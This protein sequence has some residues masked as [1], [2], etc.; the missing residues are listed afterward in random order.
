VGKRDADETY[1]RYVRRQPCCICGGIDV[2]AHHLRVGSI[3]EGVTP[4]GMGQR[5]SD[6]W[7]VP[8]CN[9]HHRELHNMGDREFWASY[10]IDPIALSMHFQVS[11]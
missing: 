6:R 9:R 7:A 1:L 4:P 3:N 11:R 8:L 2:E 10:G 5:S